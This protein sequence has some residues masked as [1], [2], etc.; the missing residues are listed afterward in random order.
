MVAGAF[1]LGP[2]GAS[3][4]EHRAQAWRFV[5]KRAAHGQF[6]RTRQADQEE[7]LEDPTGLF[8]LLVRAV[9]PV[10]LAGPKPGGPMP[11]EGLRAQTHM[12]A[13]KCCCNLKYVWQKKRACAIRFFGVAVSFYV[14]RLAGQLVHGHACLPGSPVMA[15]CLDLKPFD[16]KYHDTRTNIYAH[17]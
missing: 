14:Q 8:W 17:V 3:L 1:V 7:G 9:E 2:C 11:I 16:T 10:C 5:H 13:A 12:P 4:Q 6:L 15:C